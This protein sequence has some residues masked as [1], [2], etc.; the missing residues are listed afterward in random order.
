MTLALWTSD[1]ETAY[2]Q[3]QHTEA[4][5]ADRRAFAERSI[6]QH[7]A[8]FARF[9]RFLGARGQAES[10]DHRVGIHG[11]DQPVRHHGLGQDL[12]PV[13][14]ARADIA[15]SELIGALPGYTAFDTV[16]S[17][18]HLPALKP[19]QVLLENWDSDALNA[20]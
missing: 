9:I 14:A 20:D 19:G 11:V 3:W 1:P 13:A 8:M 16:R 6:V 7:C 17:A 5:G 18:L 2:A 15:E 10:R 12:A 4:A